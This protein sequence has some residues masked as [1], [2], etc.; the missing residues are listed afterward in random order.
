MNVET[1]TKIQTQ[2]E[3]RIIKCEQ[4]LYGIETTDDLKR[5]TIGQAQSL[6]RFCKEEE[7][8]MTK[9]AQCDLYHIIGMGNLTPPQMMKFTYLIKE[10]L[11]YRGTVK[12]LA[13]NFD[14]LSQL[15]GLPVS[16]FY[17]THGFNGLT[18]FSD[19]SFEEVND[20]SVP[21]SLSANLIKVSKGRLTEF[22]NFW[23]QK[24]KVNFSEDNFVSKANAQADYGG[25]QWSI[26]S[27]GDYLGIISASSIRQL[28]E[29]CYQSA[30]K[31]L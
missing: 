9:I 18:L 31:N 10:Y 6:Q 5:L 16:A 7:S 21:Y 24:A 15:P 23:S 13:M 4:F 25:V 12:T 11:K 1:F 3:T 19:P 28:F 29:G 17:K 14:K 27:E 8:L 20:S 22:I 2:L 26:N 30:Q